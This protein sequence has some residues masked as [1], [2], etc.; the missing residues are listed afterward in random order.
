MEKENMT[1]YEDIRSYS[2]NEVNGAIRK[3]LKDTRFI[4]V[5]SY[6]FEDPKKLKEVSNLLLSI[7]SI[8]ELQ[9]KFM[10]SIIKEWIIDRI[11][12]GVT[13]SGLDNLDKDQSYVFISNHRDIILDAALLNYIVFNGGMKTT[14][15]A[16]GDNLLIYK[17]IYHIVKLNRAFV[18]KR[19]LPARQLL[20]ASI[21]MSSYIRQRITK[22]NVSVWIAQR[23]G[24][25]KDGDDKTQSSVLKMLNLSDKKGFA[26]GFDELKIV[27]F[28]I[29][30]ERE[31][32]G[33]SKV[34]ELYKKDREG[35]VKTS[36][37]DLESMGYGLMKPKGRIHFAFG[38]PVG[39][40]KLKEMETAGCQNECIQKLASYIDSCIYKS[41]KLWPNNYFAADLLRNE[42]KYADKVSDVVRAKFLEMMADTVKTIGTGDAE[43]QKKLFL[44]MYANPVLNKEK[45]KEK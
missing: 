16:I 5:L 14:E 10:Y 31:P 28:S 4:H 38:K 22:G 37:D 1:N 30:Y 13:C 34:E 26:E 12:N 2:D 20:A 27:P 18:V 44:Q 11:T 40:D 43:A 19:N 45:T 39:L 21:K 23:E 42:N 32:C 33:I 17:W 24:R 9:T 41:Y 36:K 25:T 15:I 7:H 3:L 29:S 8:E 6:I 35:F